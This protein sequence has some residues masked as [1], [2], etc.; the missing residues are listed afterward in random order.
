MAPIQFGILCIPFQ[1]TDV[2]GPLDVLSSSSIDYLRGFQEVGGYPLELAERGIDI[3]FHYIGESMEPMTSTANCKIQPST[4]CATCPKLDYLL[5]GGPEPK[6]FLNLPPVWAN[7]LRERVD[8]VK[9]LF[10]TC[11]G[12]I[13]AAMAGILD[14]KN[15]TTNHQVVPMAKQARPEVKW[16]DERQWVVD[17]KFWTAGGACA[18]M[19]MFANWVKQNYGQDVAEAGWAALDY[20]PRDVHGKLVPLKNGLRVGKL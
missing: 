13:V 2:T 14:G 3:E 20:E 11:T 19:D 10:T 6:F 15:A 9:G 8:E 16:T 7:F 17:G 18:G 4:T 12:G 5:I 1:L